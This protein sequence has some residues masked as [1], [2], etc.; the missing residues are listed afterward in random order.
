MDYYIIYSKKEEG[1]FH[2][3]NRRLCI[4]YFL[5]SKNNL[6]NFKIWFLNI[7]YKNFKNKCR[8]KKFISNRKLGISMLGSCIDYKK[9][10]LF[11]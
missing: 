9:S 8:L 3:I 1:G 4:R 2:F 5:S 10:L 7:L 6:T 11:F